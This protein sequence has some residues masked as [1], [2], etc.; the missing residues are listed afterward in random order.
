MVNGDDLGDLTITSLGS[1][2]LTQPGDY[3][4]EILGQPL[5][6][7]GFDGEKIV[8]NNVFNNYDITYLDG[9]MTVLAPNFEP[10]VRINNLARPLF[11]AAGQAINTD[12]AFEPI[13][14][15]GLNSNLSLSFTPNAAAQVLANLA[16]AAGGQTAEDLANI[17]TS[18]GGSNTNNNGNDTADNSD[19]A[20][21]NDFLANQPC[22][23]QGSTAGI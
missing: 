22:N 21:A 13:G 20:C 11:S 16:P 17:E 6:E 14:V 3:A 5:L 1:P 15:S 23:A 8:K 19:V 12:V 2:A 7:E 18:A 4:I 10:N 9:V